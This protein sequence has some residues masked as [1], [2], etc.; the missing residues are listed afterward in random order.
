MPRLEPPIGPRIHHEKMHT[1]SEKIGI[2]A[3]KRRDCLRRLASALELTRLVAGEAAE[4]VV[5]LAGHD[6]VREPSDE[7]GTD[8]IGRRERRRRRKITWV[9]RVSEVLRRRRMMKVRR[10]E[11]VRL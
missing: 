9:R 3:E 8:V 11:Q 6:V 2:D 10:R 4:E 1:K 5:D 7:E